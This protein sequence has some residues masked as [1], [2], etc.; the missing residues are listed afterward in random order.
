[1]KYKLVVCGGTFDHFHKGHREFLRHALSISNKLLVGLTSDAYVKTKGD[2]GWIE[3]YKVRKQS[4][5]DFFY[6]EKA[7][8]KVWIESIDDIFIPKVWEQLPIEAIVV[9]ESTILAAKKI[10]ST[11]KEQGKS[12]LKIE[13]SPLIKSK[14]NEYISSSRIRNGTINRDG[15]PYINPLWFRKKLLI[16]EKLRRDFKKPFGLLIKSKNVILVIRQLA[17]HPE[18][19]PH[20]NPLPKGEGTSISSSP[21]RERK[22]VRG[23]ARMTQ[24]P[25]LITVGDVTTK[26]FNNLSLDQDISVIDFKVARQ[27]QFFSIKELGF[28][29]REKVFKVNNPAGCLT[30]ALSKAVCEI[31]KLKYDNQRIILQIEGEEDLSV[32]PLI[33]AAP[34]RSVIFYGQPNEGVVRVNVSEKTKETSHRLINQFMAT[35]SKH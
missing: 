21:S 3:D 34:L 10:N 17:E 18:S 35:S 5:E 26:T 1:M 33:L 30:P 32:L 19:F 14:D 28:S 12:T 6:K 16:T 15:R 11:R 4:L 31:F 7:K 20:P 24:S 8:D 9:S 2:S 13:I 27:K 25:Y 29:G 22:G 23:R